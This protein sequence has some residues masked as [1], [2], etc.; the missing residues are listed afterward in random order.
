MKK[1]WQT[2][3]PVALQARVSEFIEEHRLGGDDWFSVEGASLILRVLSGP[4][5][6]I[7]FG[8]RPSV[9]EE[10][11]RLASRAGYRV[12]YDPSGVTFAK[13]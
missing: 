8:A 3:P 7:A 2:I 4:L 1:T 11:D 12:A 9:R 13:A 6:D 10:L 5:S